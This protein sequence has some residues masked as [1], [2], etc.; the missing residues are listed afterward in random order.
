MKNKPTNDYI[1]ARE[2][3]E[4]LIANLNILCSSLNFSFVGREGVKRIDDN[5]RIKRKKNTAQGRDGV[6]GYHSMGFALK[7]ENIHTRKMIIVEARIGKRYF[8]SSYLKGLSDVNDI[9]SFFENERYIFTV[10]RS[11]PKR[12]YLFSF[13]DVPI[14]NIRIGNKGRGNRNRMNMIDLHICPLDVRGGK[15]GF[16]N[17][18]SLE[19]TFNMEIEK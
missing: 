13:R 15:K 6:T 19:E 1:K 9:K 5:P 17:N 4:L 7:A 14:N 18:L 8:N 11:S 3:R 10:D 12:Y 16:F 2:I